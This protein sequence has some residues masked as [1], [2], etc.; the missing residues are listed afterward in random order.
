MK[1]NEFK[2]CFEKLRSNIDKFIKQIDDNDDLIKTYLQISEQVIKELE[3][4]EKEI[5]K[6]KNGEILKIWQ[7]HLKENK[8]YG[9]LDL[10]KDI[11]EKLSEYDSKLKEL[12]LQQEAIREET[13]KANKRK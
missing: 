10:A 3:N 11:E 2:E 6:Y 1:L 8:K 5:Q 13:L 9:F 7:S 12:I 4:Q